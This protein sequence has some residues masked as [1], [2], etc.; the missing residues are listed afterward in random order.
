M[1]HLLEDFKDF[2]DHSPTSWHAAKELC[3][4]LAAVDFTPLEESEKWKLEAGKRYFIQRG[5][6]VCAFTLPKTFPKKMII[7][8]SHTDSPA[9]K[10]KPHAEIQKDGITLFE[11]ETY[12][13]PILNSW[14][15]RDLA[16]AGR[17]IFQNAQ[18]E[19]GDT[20]VFLDDSPLFIPQLPPHLD[21]DAKEKG[22]IIDKQ[23]HLCAIFSLQPEQKNTLETLIK[24]QLG[25]SSLLSYDLFLVPLEE[26]RFVGLHTDM[27]SSYRLDNLASC[28][29]CCTALASASMND[30]LQMAIFW[31]HEE[32]GSHT[33]DGALSPVLTDI[34]KRISLGISFPEEEMI[35]LKTQSLC[36]SVDV[37]HAFNPNF[38]SK[39]DPK[40][41]CLLGKGIVLKYNADK[42]YA[43]DVKTA[44]TILQAC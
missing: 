5:G 39:F 34:L 11:T 16:L 31:D 43:T 38:M 8:A 28:H 2:L 4:R 3:N 37:S 41:K 44:A 36:I 40:H 18:G 42:K 9:L 7:L 14:F 26:A 1:S 25:I 6:F 20:L 29:A 22:L 17:V 32:I 30:N 12:G 19:M 35:R 10:L 13:S 24:K 23:E 21:K 33:Q 27:I 15:N